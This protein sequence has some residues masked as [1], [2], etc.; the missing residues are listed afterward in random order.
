MLSPIHTLSRYRIALLA[1]FVVVFVLAVAAVRALE[2]ERTI[3]VFPTSV[4]AE[5]WRD[6]QQVLEQTLSA[7]AIYDDFSKTNSAHFLH[8]ATPASMLE[9]QDALQGVEVP[10]DENDDALVSDGDLEST[11]GL[12]QTTSEGDDQVDD[13]AGMESDTQNETSDGQEELGDEA[14]SDNVEDSA[15]DESDGASG[16]S[17]E[18]EGSESVEGA[19]NVGGG[20]TEAAD[21]AQEEISAAARRTLASATGLGPS[22]PTIL[23]DLSPSE[24]VHELLVGTAHAQDTT[25]AEAAEAA[26]PLEGDV[27]DIPETDTDEQGEVVEDDTGTTQAVDEF[28]QD[29]PE[30]ADGESGVVEREQDAQE[31]VRFDTNSSEIAED[32]SDAENDSAQQES[33]APEDDSSL[34]DQTVEGTSE[35]TSDGVSSG[36]W[37]EETV[38]ENVAPEDVTVCGV[39][40]EPCYLL[41]VDGFG[42]GWDLSEFEPKGFDLKLSLAGT[43]DAA[44]GEEDALYVRYFDGYTW[45][46]AHMLQL[47]GELSNYT[48]GGHFTFPLDEISSWNRLEDLRVQVEYVPGGSREARVFVDSVWVDARYS[49]PVDEELPEL[50]QLY[51][52]L[53]ALE[54]SA[55]PDTLVLPDTGPIRFVHTDENEDETFIIKSDRKVYEGL[56]RTKVYFNVT[57]TSASNERFHLQVYFPQSR[58]EVRSLKRYAQN[59]PLV[60]EKPVRQ[61][62]AQTC[63]AV[64]R[65]DDV[66]NEAGEDDAAAAQQP[67]PEPIE[68]SEASIDESTGVSEQRAGNTEM[69]DEE[70]GSNE[71]SVEDVTTSVTETQSPVGFDEGAQVADDGVDMAVSDEGGVEEGVDAGIEQGNTPSDHAST[72]VVPDETMEDEEVQ[73]TSASTETSNEDAAT[74]GADM[75]S[76]AESAESDVEEGLPQAYRYQ[77]PLPLEDVSPGQWLASQIVRRASAQEQSVEEVV[78]N[79]TIPPQEVETEHEDSGTVSEEEVVEQELPAADVSD[80]TSEPVVPLEQDSTVSAEDSTYVDTL[81]VFKD[82]RDGVGYYRC[83]TDGALLYCDELNADRT[84]CINNNAVVDTVEEVA[85]VDRFIDVGVKGGEQVVNHS[86]FTRAAQLVGIKPKRKEVPEYFTVKDSTADTHMIEGGQTLY[87]EMEIEYPAKSTGEFWIEAIGKKGGYGL[88]DP[89]WSSGWLYRMPITIDNTQNDLLTEHQVFFEINGSS[90]GFWNNVQEDGGDVRFLRQV[91]GFLESEWYDTSFAHRLPLTIATTSISDDLLSFPVYVDLADLGDDFWTNVKADGGDIRVTAGDGTSELP[92]ELVSIATTTKTGELYFQA[93]ALSTTTESTFYLYFG[94]STATNY[95]DTDTY[96]AHNVW[97]DDYVL[98]AHMDDLTTSSIENSA[99]NSNDGTK[100]APLNPVESSGK[101]GQAQDFVDDDVSHGDLGIAAGSSTVE[102]WARPDL[103]SG[104]SSEQD[105]YGF[106][107]LASAPGSGGTY[108]PWLTLGGSGGAADEVRYCAYTDSATCPTSSGAGLTAGEWYYIAAT[109]SKGGAT[110]VS[111][112]GRS[113]LNYTNGGTRNWGNTFTLGDLRPTRAIYF[114]GLIDEVRVT[115][116]IRSTAWVDTTYANMSTTTDFYATSSIETYV[117]PV[118]AELDHWTQYFSSSTEEAWF[119]VQ[120]DELAAN[121]STTIYLYYG[122]AG[123]ADVSDMYEPFTY[124][125]LTPIYYQVRDNGGGGTIEVASLIDDNVVQLNNG[126][127]S[128]LNRHQTISY[129]TFT[130]TSVV[131]ALGPVVAKASGLAAGD[132][133]APIGFAT[134]S[135]VQ[136]STRDQN[137]NYHMY[138]PFASTTVRIYDGGSGTPEQ[139]FNVGTSSAFTQANNT[140]TLGIVESTDPVLFVHD[141]SA[142]RD[143]FVAYPPTARDIYGISSSNAYVG[144]GTTGTDF[145]IACSGGGSTSV[146]GQSRGTNYT[147]TTCGGSAEGAGDAVR[148]YNTTQPIAAIQQADSDGG[149]STVYLPSLEFSAEYFLPTDAAYLAIVCSPE[150][151][152]VN[153]AVYDN[154]DSIVAGTEVTC[155]P[156]GTQ[157]GKQYLGSPDTTTYNAGYSIASTDDPQKPFYLLYEDM[158]YTGSDTGG[159]ENN[160]FGAVQFRKGARISVTDYSVGDEELSTEPLYTQSTFRFYANE[161][162]EP[163]TDPWP[164]GTEDN[165]AEDQAVTAIYAVDTGDVIRLRTGITVSNVPVYATENNVKLQYVESATCDASGLSWADV[166]LVGAGGTPWRGY[167]NASLTDG[168]TL[169]TTTLS[170]A[171]VLGSYE[172]ANQSALF[173]NDVAVGETMEHDW[174]LENNGANPNS[175]YC[176]RVVLSDDTPFASYTAYPRIETNS[177]PDEPTIV[178]PF[179]NAKVWDLTPELRFVATDEASDDVDYQVQIDDDYSFA[180][181]VVVDASSTST[182]TAFSNL[183]APSDKAPFTSGNVVA[184]TVQAPLTDGI[185]YYWRVRARDTNGSG[186]WGAWTEPARSFTTDTGLSVS[187][188]FQTTEEQ[189]VTDSVTAL[190]VTASDDVRMPGTVG[191]YG[192]VTLSGEGWSTVELEH[193]YRDLV[194]VASP[195]YAGNTVPARTPRVRNKAGDS[196]E[197]KVAGSEYTEAVTGSTVVDW[198]AMEAGSWTI[199]G[200]GAGTQV[201]AGTELVE[202]IYCRTASTTGPQTGVSFSPAFSSAPAVFHTVSSNNDATWITSS[203]HNGTD[204][205]DEPTTTGMGMLLQQA[206]GAAQDVCYDHDP[207]DVDYIAFEPGHFYPP[208]GEFEARNSADVIVGPASTGAPVGQA[209]TT[210]FPSAPAVTLAALIG[211]DGS[212]GGFAMVDTRT[213]GTASTLYMGV[214][215]DGAGGGDV[216]DRGHTDEPVSMLAF[217]H[218]TGTIRALYSGTLISTGADFDDAEI[219]NRWGSASWNDTH[220]AGTDILYQVQ[221]FGGGGWQL[222]PDTVLPGNSIGT[223]TSPIDLSDVDTG[224]YNQLRLVANFSSTGTTTTAVLYDWTISWSQGVYTPVHERPFDNEKVATTSP[225]LRFNTSDPEGD[226]ITYEVMWSTDRSFAI[227]SSSV[228]DTDPGF[229]NNDTGG[230]TDPFTSGD[231]ISFTLPDNALVEGETYWWRVRGRDPGGDNL[232]SF[233]ST[234]Q[235]ITVDSTIAVSTW[236]QTTQEQFSNDTLSGLSANVSDDV[237]IQTAVGEYG[238]YTATAGTWETITLANSYSDPVV[239]ASVRYAP[240]SETQRAARIKNKTGTSFELLVS[241]FDTQGEGT[242]NLLTGA[243]TT[244]DWIVVEAGEWTIDDGGSGIRVVADTQEDAAGIQQGGSYSGSVSDV[245]SFNPAFSSPPA[246]L[247]NVSSENDSKWVWAGVDDTVDYRNPPTASTL[248]L[249]LQRGFGDSNHAAENIDYIAFETGHGTNNGVE[250]DIQNLVRSPNNYVDCCTAGGEAVS[251]TSP[252]STVPQTIVVHSQGI[253]GGNGGWM[254]IENSGSEVSTSQVWLTMDEDGPDTT[255][256]GH[257]EEGPGIVAFASSTGNIVRIGGALSGT[258]T[259]QP[260]EFADGTGPKWGEFTW[261]DA[262]PSTSTSTYQVLYA[263]GT[264]YALIPDSALPGNETGTSASPID[265]GSLDINI[266]DDLRVR[267][268]FV[269]TPAGDC[270]TL[271]DWTVNWSEG[272]DVS[273]TAYEHDETTPLNT[274]TVRIALNGVLQPSTASISSGSWTLNNVNAFPDDIVTVWIEGAATSSRAVAVTKYDGTNDITGML[275]QERHVTLGSDEDPMLTNADLALYDNSVSGNVSIIHDVSAANDL[276]GCVVGG[277]DDVVLYVQS[278]TTYRPD[279]SSSGNVTVHDVRINGA[280]VADGNS[281]YVSGSWDNNGGF[282]A[283]TG[284]VVFTATSSEET[285]D[286]TGAA[287]SSFHQVTFGFSSGNATWTPVTALDVNGALSV[288][289][290][291]YH[292]GGLPITVAGNLVIGANGTWDTGS[293]TTTLDGTGL[294]TI[295]DSSIGQ[296]LGIVSVSGTSKTVRLQTPAIVT[297]LWIAAGNTFD[298]TANDYALEVQGDFVNTGNFTAQEGTVTFTATTTGRVVSPGP[299]EFYNLTFN[300]VGGNWAFP[301][302]DLSVG[303]DLAI[304]NGT[305]VAPVGTLTVGGDFTADATFVHNNGTVRLSSNTVGNVVTPGSNPFYNLTFFG[306]SGTWS[307]GQNYATTSNNFDILSGAVTLPATHLYVAGDF[308]NEAGSFSHN[309]GEV[310]F[311]TVGTQKLLELGGSELYDVR[312]TGA[313]A[314]AGDWY[315]TAWPYRYGI[316]IQASEVDE[317]LTD[318]P[319]YVDLAD[320]PQSLF[321]NAQSDGAD[322][323]VADT[324]GSPVPIELVSFST[325]TRTGE[326]H[327]KASSLSS[328]VDTTYYVYYGNVSALPLPDND[329]LGAEN[330]WTN[331]YLAVY[332]LN[333]DV[334][335]TGNIDAYRDSTDNNAHGDDYISAARVSGKVGYSVDMT[336]NTN[337]D[338]IM[339]PHTIADG[340]TDITASYWFNTTH[341]G[342]MGVVSGGSSS[343]D[344]EYLLFFASNDAFRLYTGAGSGGNVEWGFSAIDDGVWRHMTVVRDQTEGEARL[345]LNG[346]PDNENPEN[347]TLGALTIASGWLVV[348]QEQDSGPSYADNQDFEGYLDELRFVQGTRTAEWISTEYNNQNAPD[349]FYATTSVETVASRSFVDASALIAGDVAIDGGLVTLPTGTLTLEGS[350]QNT[351]GEFDANDGEV[352]FATSSTGHV[353]DVGGSEFYDVT[354]NDSAGGWTVTS[355]ATSTND[356]TITAAGDLTIDNG[357][358][359][360]VLGVFANNDPAG[361]DWAGST[362]ALLSG[363]G[364]TIGTRTSPGELYGTLVVGPNTDI[365]LWQ[366]SAASYD[367]DSSGSLY[368]Q[369]HAGNDGELYIWGDYVRT[370]GSDHWSRLTDFDG[371]GIGG[372]P[373]DAAVYIADGASL[374]YTNAT[375]ELRGDSTGTTTV[376]NQGSGSYAL[377]LTDSTIDAQYYSVRDTSFDGMQLF[378]STTIASLADGAFTLTFDGG[379]SMTVSSTTID[380]NPALQIERVSFSTS[381]G[382][383]SGFNVSATGTASSYWWFRNHYGN[384]DGE[385]NDGNDGNPGSIRWDDSGYTVDISGTV[386]S[387]EGVGVGTVCDDTTQVVTLV[388][389]GGSSYTAECSSADGSYSISSVSFSGD[390]TLVAYLATS[391]GA[392]AATVSRTPTVDITNFDLY[393]HY[394]I[395]R[396]EDVDPL[397]IEEMASYDDDDDATVPYNADS[398]LNTLTIDPDTSLLVFAGKEFAPG[399]DVTL[400]SGTGMSYDGSMV[401]QSGSTLTAAGTESYTVGGSWDAASDSTFTAAN[402]TVTFTAT[403][404]GSTVSAYSSFYDVVWSGAGGSWSVDVP[405]TIANDADM[406]AGTLEGASDVTVESGALAGDGEVAMTGGTV[407]LETGGSFGGTTDWTFNNLTLGDGVGGSTTKVGSGSV[408]TNGILTVSAGHTLNAGGSE[409][410]LMGAGNALSVSGT[411]N[412][413]T[414]TTTYATTT[415]MIVAPLDYY[416]VVLAP[417]GVGSPTYTF[418]AGSL[419]AETLTIGNGSDAVTVSADA[420]DPLLVVADD[421]VI[422]ANA[423][424]EAASANDLRIGGSFT[425][426]G[427]FNANAGGVVFNSTNIGET[428]TTGGDAFHALTVDGVGGGWTFVDSATSSG[429]TTLTNGTS[430]VF[431]S[432]NTFTVEGMFSNAMGAATDW[433]GSTLVLDSGTSYTVNTKGAVGDEYETLEL[434]ANTDVRIWNSTSSLYTVAPTASLYSMDHD[435]SDGALYIWGDYE[436]VTGDDHWSYATDFDG[437]DLTLGSNERSVDVRL[438]DGATTTLSGGSLSILGADGATTTIHAQTGTYGFRVT[439]GTFAAQYYEVRDTVM[440][441]VS[442]SGS[443]TVTQMGNGDFLV[444]ADGG[445]ALTIDGTVLD[446]N[447][448]KTWQNIRFALG[449]VATGTNVTVTGSS[450]SSWRF[451]PGSGALYGEDYDD[452]PAGDPGYAIFSDSAADVTIS[453]NVYSDEGM[454]VPGICNGSTQVVR[455]VVNGNEGTAQTASCALGTGYYEISGVQYGPDDSVVVYLNDTSLQAA[456][457]TTDLITSINNMHLYANRVIVRHEDTE[458]IAIKELAVYD[459]SNDPDIL[460]TAAT[461]TVP[462]TF[463]M[464]ADSKLI[465]WD[466][467][468]FAPDGDVT[469]NS[470]TGTAYDGTLELRTNAAYVSSSTVSETISVGGSWLTGSGATFSAGLSSVSMLGTSSSMVVS[471]DTSPFYDLT[472]DGTGGTWTFADRNATTTSDFTISA[473]TVVVASSSLSVGGSLTNGGSMDAAS[474]TITLLSSDPETVAF[475]GDSV[476]S[477]TFAGSGTFTMTDTDATSTGAVTISSGSVHM[478]SGTFAV[479]TSFVN[480]GGTF[481]MPVGTLRLYGDE[482]AQ[483]ITLNGS[484][485]HELRIDGSGSWLFGDALATTTGSVLVNAGALTAPMTHFGVGG[486]LDVSGSYNAN[487][488]DTYFFG[489]STGNT[490]NGNGALFANVTFNGVGGGWTVATSS[491]STGAWR[492]L[493]GASFTMATGTTLEVQDV[494]TN[495]MSDSATDWTD[496]TLYLN[497]SGTSY[498][499]NDKSTDG[500]T[501]ASFVIGDHTDVSVWNSSAATTT[502]AASSSLYSMDHGD[503]DGALSIWG[504]YIHTSGTDYWSYDRD[505]DGATLS[506]IARRPAN[507]SIAPSAYIIYSGGGLQMD[508]EANATTTVDVMGGSGTYALSFSGSSLALS[509]AQLRGMNAAGFVLSGTPSI[510]AFNNVDLVLGVDAGVAF[511]VAASVIDQNPTQTYATMYFATSSGVATGTNVKVTGATTN[512]WR[513]IP[514]YGNFDGEVHDSDGADACGAIRWQDSTCLEVSQAQYRFRA[515]DGGEGAPDNEWYDQDWSYRKP[516]TVSNPNATTLTDFALKIALPKEVDME[517]DYSDLVFTDENGTSTIPFYVESYTT[518]T[519]TVWVKVPSISG[520]DTAKVY[521][522]YGNTFAVD[523]QNGS[524]TFSAFDDF[525]DNNIDEYSGDTTNFATNG[526]FAWQKSYGLSAAGGKTTT[527]TSPGMYRTDR[528][529]S[530]GSVITYYQKVESGGEDEPCT[531]FG[532]QGSGQNYAVCLDQ[533]PSDQVVLAKDVTSND[534]SGT[535]IATDAITYTAGTY[536]YRVQIEWLTDNSIDIEVFDYTDTSVATISDSDTTYTSGGFGFGFWGQTQGWDYFIA[537]PYAASEPTYMIGSQQQGGGATWRAAQNTS[538]SQDSNTPFRV[539]VSVENSGLTITDQ[540]FRL[541]YASKTGYGSCG[542]VPSVSYN[543]VP[544]VA[545]CGVSP[546]CMVSSPQFDDQDVTTQLLDTSSALAFTAGYMVENPSNQS[547]S[548]TVATSTLTEIEYAIELTS[549]ASDSSY[550]LRTTNGGLELDSYAQIP[551]VSV[552]GV[553]V[554]TSWTLNNNQPIYLME[555]EAATIMATGTATDV[556]GDLLYATS[557]IYRSGVGPTCLP[558]E[559]NCYQLSSFDCVAV[560]CDTTSCDYECSADLQYFAEPTDIGTY[561]TESWDAQLFV[562]DLTG[563]VATATAENVDVMTMHALAVTSGEINYGTLELEQDTDADVKQSDLQNTGNAAIDVQVE[564]TDMTGGVGSTIPAAN[565]LYSTSSFTYSS[566]VICTALSGTA[567]TVEVDLDKPTSTTPVTDSLYWGIYIP[568]NTEAV[569]HT[570]HNTFYATAD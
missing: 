433:S 208:T 245:V 464:P 307:F 430:L 443:P 368:S 150:W 270:P 310:Q 333:E 4:V 435:G 127:T 149:E 171:D 118:T 243:S 401:L 275:L 196:F 42:L 156:S 431:G 227:A 89:W 337:T 175:S 279:S 88:L 384:Y 30:V 263:T 102:V 345:Y 299:S 261:N 358:R 228:S 450:V 489:T 113:V 193:N 343:N 300:G 173:P 468:T 352:L 214:D 458:P 122:N 129:S 532:V 329:T 314:G 517:S 539:R 164:E 132:M 124:A 342:Q 75:S 190:S 530:Q 12:E 286:S 525:E 410:V 427:T 347:T 10:V 24:W 545:G 14:L 64:W 2:E 405:L 32:V 488:G 27:N 20:D 538:I 472:F 396:H 278:G 200:G 303:N 281:I 324:S 554:I 128:T 112:N 262:V 252:F 298:V 348:G 328:S 498:T 555:G 558:N 335:G 18:V 469:L 360:A 429:N 512:Y 96:G 447:P 425:N 241:N 374:T 191:E 491:T 529:I 513:L 409:W 451:L 473:G 565:Q 26:V 163:P 479:R 205:A 51:D 174:V 288:S 40:D 350:L 325:T 69:T 547:T 239:V 514:S 403:S 390:A 372:S 54:D 362:L 331:N 63:P 86:V 247:A 206:Y 474:T 197:I 224:T 363:T 297:D 201:I 31:E 566:C 453:G 67:V 398:V 397:T 490:V 446:Q 452:D 293:A 233:W 290:G 125:T 138:A 202:H 521:V 269:C 501:Y 486:S 404:T 518:A 492:L 165:I 142:P 159:D 1:A 484:T 432:G 250:F 437:A 268:S 428:V 553:P 379:S 287:T 541:Q 52:E 57:N 457:V 407:T 477:L 503:T 341:D 230:D 73:G 61:P 8:A 116:G 493:Q 272:I 406:L 186:A 133:L 36:S 114:D 291:T 506:G 134:T 322:I 6:E 533:Y 334:T 332:H 289:Y 100:D 440:D 276:S 170:T 463:A 311:N 23:P 480:S 386:Y 560:T 153:L 16:E 357:V 505:F 285:I 364:Y 344:N 510:T 456:N 389:D 439:G 231:S 419:G 395:A 33:V 232:W 123:A 94:S 557:T 167:S 37:G 375:L 45:H 144:V 130:A 418:A 41:E 207:E 361:T 80:S 536:W 147:N 417:Q 351:G 119:W 383:T 48:N 309:H 340:A 274:G 556:N 66:A 562:T 65:Y 366:S 515:D 408:T 135:Y 497:A 53:Q 502:V 500:D 326:L 516:I 551:E 217:L 83:P 535:V 495:N 365:R 211:V 454:T 25:S 315:S 137:S 336:P 494:F 378:G 55:Q 39:R 338:R 111:I 504:E 301:V 107:I 108:S 148:Y 85:Y 11:D 82:E 323:R 423:T 561:S 50:P 264:S 442:L 95:A 109:S 176:F 77:V 104:G 84:N 542:A 540:Q 219:G 203:V 266:Y 388:V 179:D 402:S 434:G 526:S 420:N 131:K 421:V 192:T 215:E 313:S 59:V 223:S 371:T 499:V 392:H 58:G 466:G 213:A 136:L 146:T 259:S 235:S 359:A 256:R 209:Y 550:C 154:T 257:T 548:M 152:D 225:T 110:G 222:I 9:V 356:W 280:L 13:G 302:T 544:N 444:K 117:A 316:T 370:S 523:S 101:F 249:Y 476:G 221:Y 273:G 182:P 487:G 461:T 251:F 60:Y 424:Y 43:V 284:V 534:G 72:D 265:L 141:N 49:A 377:S 236:H 68:E 369:D 3:H 546:V 393:E 305:V 376:Q 507:V 414:S 482:V 216:A 139:V 564:G 103:L 327:F 210:A 567:S 204:T 355:D 145:D 519:A 98:V 253:Y 382:I 115:S 260:I 22:T 199:E 415:N 459:S 412:A 380:E 465:V 35:P 91:D 306:G 46:I 189:F 47:R 467:K 105:Q 462:H 449:A 181:P 194:V 157:P 385:D 559:N 277:C 318:F 537:R 448:V 92:R 81:P 294:A 373:R 90:T 481:S 162:A 220:A 381:T 470:G 549:F 242:T 246:V 143:G 320:A 304:T 330:V 543:D 445:T 237:G 271:Y 312:F 172:E 527:Q 195:R 248:G 97:D 295:A 168:D 244:V 178:A 180:D 79:H 511:D 198:V 140:G 56:T 240:T 552:N 93:N 292:A 187:T 346:Q 367:V 120:V 158:E 283:G 229:V 7:N 255:S 28:D 44:P 509:Y 569:P 416:N 531:Y 183:T 166:G 349:T 282:V 568:T 460:F 234:E 238:T 413:D 391:T 254:L 29:E 478:P 21:S 258:I 400:N 151:G 426:S 212:D 570:G 321:D 185:T 106:T 399:G 524:S 387:G 520:N 126:A 522:Y 70:S 184:Y 436:R 317:D 354:F 78:P 34:S 441:G 15:D 483:S 76:P 528:T 62:L 471:P 339:I 508:G 87:F 267:S 563:N 455:L 308:E 296:D 121:A 438:A 155:S 319:V 5:G 38:F 475:N 353:I 411:F 226:D 188:W 160:L 485:V 71:E 74:D 218:A 17:E 177:A 161:D 169:S 99:G 394:V 496:S 19:E 422:A